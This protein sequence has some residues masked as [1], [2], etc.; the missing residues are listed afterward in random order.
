MKRSIGVL[1][2]AA[3]LVAACSGGAPSAPATEPL[4]TETE[5]SACAAAFDVAAGGDPMF[6]AV[7]D[8]YPAVK[9]CVDVDEWSA[10][11]DR[12]DGAGFTGSATE[13][14]TIICKAPEIAE[15]PL[16]ANLR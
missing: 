8:L 4:A 5:L 16:C 15:E 11:F 2:G 10:E 6:D 1:I 13:V 14:L 12:V 9:A 3:V 7:E